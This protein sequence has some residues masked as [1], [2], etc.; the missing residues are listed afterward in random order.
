VVTTTIR[1]RFDGRSTAY[2]RSSRSQRRGPLAAVSLTSIIFIYFRRS[3]QPAHTG[4]PTVVTYRSSNGR[5]KVELQLNGNRTLGRIA[6]ESK[7]NH[8]CNHGFVSISWASCFIMPTHVQKTSLGV[9]IKT[10]KN[11][12][13]NAFLR[14]WKLLLLSTFY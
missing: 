3:E 10:I 4:R 2:Q 11:F 5:S 14:R 6:V 1:L 9:D 12:N 13:K 7:S 8:S